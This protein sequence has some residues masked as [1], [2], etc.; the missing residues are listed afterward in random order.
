[1]LILFSFIPILLMSTFIKKDSVL[2]KKYS[3]YKRYSIN[4]ETQ[5]PEE[6]PHAVQKNYLQDYTIFKKN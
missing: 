2:T 6:N 4:G 1:M 3:F 5:A